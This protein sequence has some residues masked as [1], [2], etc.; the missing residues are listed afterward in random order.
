MLNF[1]GDITHLDLTHTITRTQHRHFLARGPYRFKGMPSH[2]I[3]YSMTA[4]KDAYTS[5][6]FL[7]Y[8]VRQHLTPALC[9]QIPKVKPECNI[10][11]TFIPLH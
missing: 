9:N 5:S 8:I 11:G 4:G 1:L 10:L 7:L 3:L 2:T 6:K